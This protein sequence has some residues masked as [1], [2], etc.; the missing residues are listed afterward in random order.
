MV[1]TGSGDVAA[2]FPA[3]GRGSRLGTRQSKAF[4]RVAGS[5]LI[6]HALRTLA[7]S[8]AVAWIIVAVQAADVARM[9]RLVASAKLTKV[10]AVVAGG[11]SRSASVANALAA[12]PKSAQWVLIHD[13][14]RPCVTTRL[15][16]ESIKQARRHGAVACGLPASVTVKAVDGQQR[17]RLTLDRDGVWFV[18]T[19]Q[20]FRRDWLA[21]ALARADGQLA[22]MP[23]DAAMLEW[24]GY[25][26]RMIPGDPLNVKVT[27]K[28]DLLIAE[29]LAK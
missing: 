19:P 12:V 9:R 11:S 14:A 3:S 4:V 24:A 28:D 6:A 5:P 13:G 16:T 17:V 15:I 8:P 18:Q 20:V 1:R 21:D 29:T 10:S 27:T 22:Q 25:P 23:D 26:V 2:I 7:Q